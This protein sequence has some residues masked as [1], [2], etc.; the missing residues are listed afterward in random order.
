VDT[1]ALATPGAAAQIGGWAAGGC[2]VLVAR[3]A[4]GEA[5]AGWG[6]DELALSCWKGRP[7]WLQPQADKATLVALRLEVDTG[8][9]DST[10]GV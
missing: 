1:A 4:A 6:G 10:G 2:V 5:E 7:C 3:S 9:R 8:A